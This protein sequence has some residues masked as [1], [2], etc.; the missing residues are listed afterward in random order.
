MAV[1]PGKYDDIATLV[2]DRAKVTGQGG[3]IVIIIGGDKGDGFSMQADLETT[4]MVP[5]LLEH[6]AQ[7]IRKDRGKL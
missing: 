3:V 4:I 5:E 1:G 2:K 6:V 7:Q